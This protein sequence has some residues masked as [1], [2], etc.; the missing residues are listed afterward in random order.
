MLP[1]EFVV[2]AGAHERQDCPVHVEFRA[3]ALAEDSVEL[4]DLGSRTPRLLPVQV[5]RTPSGN[6]RATFVIEHLDAGATRQYA[7]RKTDSRRSTPPVVRVRANEGWD[8]VEVRQG[9]HP[10]FGYRYGRAQARPFIYPL[11]DPIGTEVTRGWPVVETKAGETRD[12]VH[13]KSCWVAWGD[14]NGVDHWSE[15]PGHGRQVHRRFAELASGAVYGV[16]HACN[17]WV[18]ASGKRQL[19]EERR[20]VAYASSRRVRIIDFQITFRMTEGPVRFGDTKEG[21]ILSVRVATWMDASKRGTLCNSYG[22]IGEDECW[23]KPAH[24]VDYYGPVRRKV[25]GI[26]IFDHPE[27]LRYPTTWHIR[28]YGL[29]TANPFGLSH[30]RGKGHDGS[31]TFAAGSEQVWRYRMLVHA[32]DIERAGVAGH[33][34]N[35]VA[36][37]RVIAEE[38]KP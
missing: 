11:T 29:M 30:F 22:G 16:V 36:P 31:V 21:G 13:H 35:Y 32:G 6:Y 9:H 27:N 10:V 15:E 23:G 12:H 4:I 7:I 17:D 18:D 34:L 28:N 3:D 25:A 14:V 38:G 20:I 33:F 1:V 24:W 8:R 2:D 37:P 26:A 5:C 19:Q